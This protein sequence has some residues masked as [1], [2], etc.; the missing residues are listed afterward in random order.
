MDDGTGGFSISDALSGAAVIISG[1]IGALWYGQDERIKS[2]EADMKEHKDV[3]HAAL[4]NKLDEHA[5]ENR[6]QN[7]RLR[8]DVREDI[9]ELR[10]FIQTA[11]TNQRNH[12]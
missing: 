1:L 11:F 6:A 4:F 3:A 8:T 5:K 9:S 2:L 10:E 7:E 12:Q